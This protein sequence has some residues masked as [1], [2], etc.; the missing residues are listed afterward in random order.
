MLAF[1]KL[2]DKS[3][4]GDEEIT[5]WQ[6]SRSDKVSEPSVVLESFVYLL[7]FAIIRRVSKIFWACPYPKPIVSFYRPIDLF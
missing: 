4:F 3:R 2:Y 6:G 5:A 7:Q 1:V